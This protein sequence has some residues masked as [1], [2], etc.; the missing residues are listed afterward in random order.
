MGIVYNV[1]REH[2]A[3]FARP[4]LQGKFKT[5]RSLISRDIAMRE[6]DRFDIRK[7]EET[8]Q[9]LLSR[10]YIVSATSRGAVH[11]CRQRRTG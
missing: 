9:R 1:N 5:D 7:I 8:E 2:H 10:P 11:F 3:V 4:L 6:G